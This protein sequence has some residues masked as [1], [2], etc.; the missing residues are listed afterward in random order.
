[1]AE[2]ADAFNWIFPVPAL[3]EE[4]TIAD[5][6]ARRRCATTATRAH[7]LAIV[8]ADG[9][10]DPDA[11]LYAASHFADLKVGAARWSGSTT[12]SAS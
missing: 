12:A 7:D 11:P 3:N 8:D 1:V 2:G 10:L 5:S 9:R 4:V 6:V